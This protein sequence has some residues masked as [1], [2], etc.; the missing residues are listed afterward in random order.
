MRDAPQGIRTFFV[1]SIARSRDRLFS[2]EEIAL[3]F[4]SATGAKA[5]VLER[6]LFTALNGRSSTTSPC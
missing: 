6:F 1:T 4:L 5:L 3:L 2:K